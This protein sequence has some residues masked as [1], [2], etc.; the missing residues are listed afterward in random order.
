MKC[1]GSE[2][3]T[4]VGGGY[5]VSG[6]AVS[7]NSISPNGVKGWAFRFRSHFLYNAD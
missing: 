4:V 3:S 7:S 5:F 1:S 2:S 6:L